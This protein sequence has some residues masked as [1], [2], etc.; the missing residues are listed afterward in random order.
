MSSAQS[1]FWYGLRPAGGPPGR[2]VHDRDA[3]TDRVPCRAPADATLS[4]ARRPSQRRLAGRLRRRGDRSSYGGG[5]RC[6]RV[7]IAE[8][9]PLGPS[10]RP[11]HM[12]EMSRTGL[13]PAVMH[14]GDDARCSGPATRPRRIAKPIHRSSV[15][16]LVPLSPRPKWPARTGLKGKCRSG[17]C[18]APK[19][20]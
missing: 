11:G 17:R 18:Q 7:L 14:L 13:W 9:P 6:I 20:S 1:E 8:E 4:P 3:G 10:I 19:S 5:L 15:Q 12:T 16:M 2:Q